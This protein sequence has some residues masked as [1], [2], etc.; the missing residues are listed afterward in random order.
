MKACISSNFHS[1]YVARQALGLLPYYNEYVETYGGLAG[2]SS[3]LA[4]R[5][6]RLSFVSPISGCRRTVICDRRSKPKSFGG[7]KKEAPPKPCLSPVAES[8][9]GRGQCETGRVRCTQPARFSRVGRRVKG[10]EGKGVDTRAVFADQIH[11]ARIE[12]LCSLASIEGV[13]S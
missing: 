2:R 10:G 9:R 5:T 12:V 6:R 7:G 3:G 4:A 8:R 13:V 11:L 1:T